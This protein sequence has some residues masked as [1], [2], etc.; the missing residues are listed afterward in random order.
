MLYT[1]FAVTGLVITVIFGCLAFV[2]KKKGYVPGGLSLAAGNFIE[3]Y[4]LIF[5]PFLFAVFLF[6]RLLKLEAFPNGFHVDELSMAVDAKSILYHGT[7]R[8]GIRFPVY[9]RN[10]G[11]G[12]N[13][14]YI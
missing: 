12:Q 5:L 2:M 6:S 1:S 7:D 14:L 9:F 8:G 13:A 11:G 4:H 10:Y 3:H